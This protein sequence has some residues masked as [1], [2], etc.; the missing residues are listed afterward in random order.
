[1][2]LKDLQNLVRLLHVFGLASA[3]SVVEAHMSLTMGYHGPSDDLLYPGVSAS[4]YL[5]GLTQTSD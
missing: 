4:L 2:R 5:F 3:V 1:M